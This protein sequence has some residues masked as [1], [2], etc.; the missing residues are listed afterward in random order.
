MAISFLH[1]KGTEAPIRIPA[2]GLDLFVRMTDAVASV[3]A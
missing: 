2:I 1:S 3:V